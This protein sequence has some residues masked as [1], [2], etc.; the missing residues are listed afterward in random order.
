[1]NKDSDMRVVEVMDSNG[2]WIPFKFKQLEPGNIFRMFESTG[3]PV[4]GTNGNTV[5]TAATVPQFDEDGTPII[6]IE[7]E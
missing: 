1:M 7:E 2:K 6:Y 5:F 4:V 3:E